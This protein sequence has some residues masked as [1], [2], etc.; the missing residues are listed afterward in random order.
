MKN[1]IKKL[2]KTKKKK[3]EIGENL[4]FVICDVKGI[5]YKPLKLRLKTVTEVDEDVIKGIA[6][7]KFYLVTPEVNSLLACANFLVTWKHGEYF[8]SQIFVWER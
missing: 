3:T 7:Q 5:K 4:H 8:G 1:P 2:K 6:H